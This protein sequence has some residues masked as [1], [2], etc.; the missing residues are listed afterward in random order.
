MNIPKS[1]IFRKMKREDRVK[2]TVYLRLKHFNTKTQMRLYYR[3][4][5]NKVSL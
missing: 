2:G 3:K 4:I 1:H 5:L